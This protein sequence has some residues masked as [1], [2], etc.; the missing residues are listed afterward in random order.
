MQRYWKLLVFCSLLGIGGCGGSSDKGQSGLGGGPCDPNDPNSCPNGTCTN[1]ICNVAGGGNGGVSCQDNDGDG[2]GLGCVAGADCNDSDVTQGRNEKCGDN[3]DNDCD[4]RVD[5]GLLTACACDSSCTSAPIGAPPFGNSGFDTNTD[6]SDGVGVDPS[7]N[8]V[9][10]SR[11]VNKSYIWVANTR[12]G[13]LSKINTR[14]K[15]G[16]GKYVEEGRYATGP[17]GRYRADSNNDGTVEDTLSSFADFF[18]GED[19]S[20]TTVNTLGEAFVGNRNGGSVVKLLPGECPDTNGDGVIT[21]SSAWNNVYAWGNNPQQSSDDCV[22]WRTEL[23]GGAPRYVRAMAA[24]DV[25]GL[26]G[27]IESYVWVG[28]SDYDG[29]SIWKID[30]RSGEVLFRTKV[31]GCKPYGFALDGR[32]PQNLWVSCRS[33][34]ALARI[35]TSRCTSAGCAAETTPASGATDFRT[36]VGE[37]IINPG[38]ANERNCDTAVKQRIAVPQSPYGITVDRNQRVWLGSDGSAYR[39]DP[40]A[41][42][43]SSGERWARASTGTSRGISVD[44]LLFAYAAR[45]GNRVTQV[46]GNAMGGGPTSNPFTLPS[47][48]LDNTN[49]NA[50]WGTAVDFDGKVWVLGKDRS[51]AMVLSPTTTFGTVTVERDAVLN[52][53]RTYTYSDM[54]GTQLRL[55]TNPVGYYR[56]LFPANCG[57]GDTRWG[58]LT[59]EAET[60][61]GTSLRVY[62]RTGNDQAALS[63]ANWILVAEMPGSS[64][65]VDINAALAN[66]GVQAGKLLEVE[67]QLRT[68]YTSGTQSISPVVRFF[69]AGYTCSAGLI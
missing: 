47:V 67:M 19:P 21:T 36:C 56:H 65:P 69:D 37:G 58:N 1:G 18:N 2:F 62:V 4:G 27:R 15:D 35:D 44:A 38:T 30:G 64:P 31:A 57:T 49:N 23:E 34:N 22:A 41:T 28:D 55:A 63:G 46:D 17:E 11:Q 9:L 42:G 10:S 32:N 60:P 66:A 40:M 50:S 6:T 8:L 7:G 48:E 33:N 39:Y 5:E 14:V 54:T 20:R 53:G 3:K 29:G 52:L 61:P 59:W 43:G 26:D 16:A 51:V 24:Q 12:Q 25:F 45:E 13:T 68:T